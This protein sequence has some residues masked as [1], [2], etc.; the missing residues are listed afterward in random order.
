MFVSHS[1]ISHLALIFRNVKKINSYS[2]YFSGDWVGTYLPM[3]PIR[4]TMDCR[5]NAKKNL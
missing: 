5:D 4:D 3:T 2:G 1:V